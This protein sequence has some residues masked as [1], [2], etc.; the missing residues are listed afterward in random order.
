MPLTGVLPPCG[1]P[2]GELWTGMG[3]KMPPWT[4]V[5]PPYGLPHGELCIEAFRIWAKE[6]AVAASAVVGV[7][8]I[9]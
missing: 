5:L 6:G 9:E 4:G 1:L 2:H 3:G 8:L 7:L